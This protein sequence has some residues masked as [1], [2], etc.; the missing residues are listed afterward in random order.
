[1]ASSTA[2][3]GHRLGVVRLA[4]TGA[5]AAAAFVALCWLGAF[6]PAG[7]ATHMYLQLFT[8]A[9]M[10]SIE[11]LLE[12]LCWSAAFGLVAG[13]LVALI[14]NALGALDRR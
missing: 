11:A 8:D 9:D 13:A 1:M 6:L 10:T 5:V 3:A 14:Y 12:G 4:A 7:P 2:V